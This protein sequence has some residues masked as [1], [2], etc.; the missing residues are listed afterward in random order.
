MRRRKFC[1][2][3][4]LATAG[5]GA[6]GVT[7]AT[8]PTAPTAPSPPA[9]PPPEEASWR[10]MLREFERLRAAG[11][12]AL[13]AEARR[14]FRFRA[15]GGT[16]GGRLEPFADEMCFLGEAFARCAYAEAVGRGRGN[17]AFMVQNL[18][19]GRPTAGDLRQFLR[20]NKK[21][22]ANYAGPVD[23]QFHMLFNSGTLPLDTGDGCSRDHPAFA[24]A[25]K[26][27]SFWGRAAR[28][29]A[30]ARTLTT[31]IRVEQADV[32]QLCKGTAADTTGSASAG[33]T[34]SAAF[35][36]SFRKEWGRRRERF[37]KEKPLNAGEMAFA[38]GLLRYTA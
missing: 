12:A 30:I 32:A 22:W 8:K 23:G 14:Q 19:M 3:L 25:K 27:L 6:G 9:S 24:L 34:G 31:T 29:K 17:F 2:L 36:A 7:G 15:A 1:A 33:T 4:V 11:L 5:A 13:P 10:G 28:A 37:P 35:W 26:H 21:P 18:G 38:A 20:P 16:T